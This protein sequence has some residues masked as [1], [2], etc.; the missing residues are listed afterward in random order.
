M[1]Q[2]MGDF[3]LFEGNAIAGINTGFGVPCPAHSIDDRLYCRND[4]SVFDLTAND[5]TLNIRADVGDFALHLISAFE[6]YESVRD[7]DADQLNID[8]LHISRSPAKLR[9]QPGAATGE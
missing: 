4:A 1:P 7:F 9:L 5:V 2:E 6:D 8:V 3:T